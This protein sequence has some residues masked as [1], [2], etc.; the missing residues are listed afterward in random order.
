MF[1][2]PHEI[3]CHATYNEKPDGESEIMGAVATHVVSGLSCESREFGS[4]YRNREAAK[5]E[6]GALLARRAE[7]ALMGAPVNDDA[8]GRLTPCRV[9]DC[10]L[11][12]VL[13]GV[14]GSSI[15]GAGE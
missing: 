2:Q 8:V 6:L 15:G 11:V 12:G 13:D 10:G 4:Y 7:V 9:V 5:A 3:A 1:F 14:T